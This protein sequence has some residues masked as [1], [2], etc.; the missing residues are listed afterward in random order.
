MDHDHD[1]FATALGRAGL[2]AGP[3]APASAVQRTYEDLRQRILSLELPPNSI[4]SRTELAKRYGVS[5]TPVREALQRLEAEGLVD[6]FPQSK[7]QVSRLV[8]SEIFQAHFLRLAIETEVMRRLAADCEPAVIRRLS[9]LVAM[10]E[11]VGT[12]PEELPAFQELDELFHQTL[13]A[14]VGQSALHGLLRARSGHLNRLRRLDLPGPGKIADILA[15]HRAIIAALEAHDPERAQDAVRAHLSKTVSRVEV[16]R[17][18]HP[19]YFA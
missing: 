1:D 8:T 15:A 18:A 14:A 9:S 5:Q 10:Q 13:L 11:A 17:D 2:G 7:T 6:I 4:L 3:A 19:D 16:I 12:D